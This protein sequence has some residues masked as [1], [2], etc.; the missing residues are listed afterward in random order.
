VTPC[1]WWS[2]KTDT[3][4]TDPAVRVPDIPNQP[5]GRIARCEPHARKAERFY[6]AGHPPD[7]GPSAHRIGVVGRAPKKGPY[8]RAPTGP[9]GAKVQVGGILW[10]P[11]L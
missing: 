3:R 10:G 7:I 1:G 11:V 5:I 2:A 9:A 6:R 4:C 8:L